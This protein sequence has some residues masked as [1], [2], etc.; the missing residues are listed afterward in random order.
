MELSKKKSKTKS[1]TVSWAPDEYLC[2]VQP[3]LET[4]CPS[5][6]GTI[7]SL[8]G[9]SPSLLASRFA[10]YAKVYGN[11]RKE[12]TSRKLKSDIECPQ[13]RWGKNSKNV[14]RLKWK[15]PP[16]LDMS[17]NKWQVAA[18]EESKEAEAQKLREMRVPQ[19]FYPRSS[20]IP[21]NPSISSDI[22]DEHYNDRQTPI[23]P[24]KEEKAADKSDLASDIDEEHYDDR[25]TPI[26]PIEEEKAVD[27]SDLAIPVSTSIIFRPP[28]LP[29]VQS[30]STYAPVVQAP[31]GK[32]PSV[33]ML[34]GADVVAAALTALLKTEQQG[35][36]IDTD[37]LAR[38]LGNPKMIEQL[39]DVQTVTAPVVAAKQVF[40]PVPIRNMP[41]IENLINDQVGPVRKNGAPSA[42]AISPMV[43]EQFIT[44]PA[45]FAYPPDDVP[46]VFGWKEETLGLKQVFKPVPIRNMPEIENLIND[47]AGPVRKNGAPSAAAISPM[48]VEQFVSGPAPFAYPPDDVP[49]VF[50]WKE[51]TLPILMPGIAPHRNLSM[52][53]KHV[54]SLNPMVLPARPHFVTNMQQPSLISMPAAAQPGH[55]PFSSYAAMTANPT[56]TK[57]ACYYQNLIKQYGGKMQEM[58]YGSI[59]QPDSYHNLFQNMIQPDDSNHNQFQNMIQVQQNVKPVDSK[60]KF[61]KCCKYFRSSKGCQKGAKCPYRHDILPPKNTKPKMRAGGKLESPRVKKKKKLK[62]EAKEEKEE[63]KMRAGGKG[64]LEGTLMQ[65]Q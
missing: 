30:V 29:E 3:V 43:V 27:D 41:E 59:S 10:I 19:A 23:I 44:E 60:A 55:F 47:Q 50:G 58:P 52:I 46:P 5:R 64:M 32:I 24:I 16:K 4:D 61:Q 26:I 22:D 13:I 53:P 42:A 1:K 31:A 63:A 8:Y 48:V 2:E 54:P 40:K 65:T 12:K 62:N 11:I 57:D 7:P 34:P 9:R 21:D 17:C 37:L 6:I 38:I 45:P 18:G 33:G 56:P 28:S 51:G 14:D 35:T 36:M 25:Q 15:C 39:R 49:Q 20:A